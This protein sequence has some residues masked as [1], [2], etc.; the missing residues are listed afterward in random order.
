MD[1]AKDTIYG[2]LKSLKSGAAVSTISPLFCD[3]L[4]SERCNLRCK[5]CH[6]WKSTNE[7]AVTIDEYKKFILSL[8]DFDRPPLEINLGGG[9]PLLKSGILDL[10]RFCALHGIKPAISTNA[11]LINKEMAKRISESGLSRL[12]ISLESLDEGV[13]DFITGTPGAYRKLMRGIEYLRKYWRGAPL[14]IHTVLTGQNIDTAEEMAEWVNRDSFFSGIAFIA[15]AQPFLT[16]TVEEWYRHEEYGILWPKSHS[17]AAAV[18]D[19]LISRK[20]GG[21][22]IINPLSQLDAY[23]KYYHDPSAFARAYNCNFGEYIFNVNVLG[24]VHLCCF[25]NPI[26]SIKQRA[27]KEIW[28]S[29]EARRMRESMRHCQKSCNNIMN[30]YFQDDADGAGESLHDG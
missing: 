15:L 20:R 23:K 12:S 13:H 8:K 22:K 24:L 27:I 25:M 9:E 26:G 6:F 14:H 3:V 19:R 11:T 7:D 4:V 17:H 1:T 21:D 18:I 10:V 28:Y 5:K 2:R 16:P 29:Q 30:C